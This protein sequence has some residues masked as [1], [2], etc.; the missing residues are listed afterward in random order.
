LSWSVVEV[1]MGRDAPFWRSSS[2]RV[3]AEREENYLGLVPRAAVSLCRRPPC[4]VAAPAAL[5]VGW[6][7]GFAIECFGA[8]FFV[9][10]GPTGRSADD[11]FFAAKNR[12]D[13]VRPAF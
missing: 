13:R 11:L 10:P 12:K 6:A 1:G 9:L 7:R 2:G 8:K 4:S 3:T 5:V